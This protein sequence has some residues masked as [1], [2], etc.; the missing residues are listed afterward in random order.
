MH[1]IP[2]TSVCR[3]VDRAA[4]VVGGSWILQYDRSQHQKCEKNLGRSHIRLGPTHLRS[5]LTATSCQPIPTTSNTSH[6]TANLRSM[7]PFSWTVVASAIHP[8]YWVMS[9][10]LPIIPHKVMDLPHRAYFFSPLNIRI[11]DSGCPYLSFPLIVSHVLRVAG[12]RSAFE[13]SQR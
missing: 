9:C 13:R 12:S 7:S 2:N 11:D 3:S 4:G 6:S 1:N 10:P 5:H 8:I